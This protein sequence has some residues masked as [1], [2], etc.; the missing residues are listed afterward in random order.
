ME[1]SEWNRLDA[2]FPTVWNNT[3]VSHTS[4]FCKCLSLF[5]SVYLLCIPT[6]RIFKR[7]QQREE[8]MQELVAKVNNYIFRPRNMYM[9]EMTDMSYNMG[10][11]G[12]VEMAWYEIALTQDKIARLE[13]IDTFDMDAVYAF[14]WRDTS[15]DHVNE[16]SVETDEEFQFRWRMS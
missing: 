11:G 2:E 12:W 15:N 9:K 6:W 13:Q 16:N 8:E 1:E 14:C 5:P 10:F 3:K 7:A 4:V